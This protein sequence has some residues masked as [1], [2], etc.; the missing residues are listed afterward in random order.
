MQDA[1]EKWQVSEAMR[2][3]KQSK[4]LAE[5]FAVRRKK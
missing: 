3:G 4:A 5:V 2:I 1:S